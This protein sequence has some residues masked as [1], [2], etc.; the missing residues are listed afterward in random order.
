MR[1]LLAL[2]FLL[3]TGF[4]QANLPGPKTTPVVKTEHVRAELLVHAPE[5]VQPGGKFWVG[6]SLEHAPHW[7][8]YWKNSGD[9]GL[10][11]T[12]EFQLPAG[13][14]A[15]D[16][17]WPLPHKIP[18]GTL[19][20]FGF[21]NTVLLPV[22]VTV[23][24]DFAGRDVLVQLRAN[25]LV[26]RRECIPEE[27]ELSIRIPAQG[28]TAS[29]AALFES[30]F[31]AVPAPAKSATVQ[32]R[33]N[34]EVLGLT[35]KG[36]PAN[37]QGK[38]LLVFPESAE[39]IETA[40][41]ITQEWK[42][43]EWAAQIKL[44]KH[45]GPIPASMAWAIAPENRSGPM[46]VVAKVEGIPAQNKPAASATPATSTTP[47]AGNAT[48]ISPAL[49]AAL[50]ANNAAQGA[51]GNTATTA[52]QGAP[53]GLA[54]ALLG[55]L[56]GGMIL[57]LMPCVFPVLAIKVLHLTEHASDPRTRV[58]TGLAYSVGVILSFVLLGALLIVLRAAGESLG[59]GFQLQNPWVVGALA[60]LFTLIGLNL[61]GWFEVGQ[62][63]PSSILNWETRHP[64]VDAFA[65]GVLAVAVASP[66][67][68]PFMGASLGLTLSLPAFEALLIFAAIGVGM[69]APYLLL[70]SVPHLV[71]RLPRPG[72]WMLAFKKVMAVPMFLTVAWLGW[73]LWQQVG[74]P[75]APAAT[76]TEEGTWKTW[77]PE[78]VQQTLAE[79]KPVF[80]DFTAAWCVTCQVN[81]K[82]VLNDAALL[83]DMKAK[84]VVLMV[85]DWTRKDERISAALKQ[86]GRSGVPVYLLLAPGKPPVVMSELL[87]VEEVRGHLA[88]LP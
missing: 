14:K 52:V 87:S 68:A 53:L 34:G 80:V 6:L 61:L 18:I 81:K 27:A 38:N 70:V 65:S 48:G 79:G 36:L 78:R 30:T 45:R 51:S 15:G 72:A 17:A 76:Q 44:S 10:P 82:A 41:P 62:V 55:A 19:A 40:A 64:M 32:S 46:R 60:L 42:G 23:G 37:W 50:D 54:L 47:A 4:A 5:G 74:P 7:H 58:Q 2:V 63:V 13:L 75:P 59:W 22:P 88:Q 8:T 24:K 11:T 21:E 57:N 71:E 9:S 56:V 84:G 67:T 1:H 31:K 86:L 25:W 26:C 20:N 3:V 85:A 12:L 66:C 83:A 28:S 73:V 16:I 35:V 69:A 39:V 29:N 33:V 43:D 49:Q 77:S